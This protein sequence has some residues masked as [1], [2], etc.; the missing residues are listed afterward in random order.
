MKN[1]F[2]AHVSKRLVSQLEAPP[3]TARACT[4]CPALP[5]PLA[6]TLKL[7]S[8]SLPIVVPTLAT[9]VDVSIYGPKDIFKCDLLTDKGCFG[10]AMPQVD[11]ELDADGRAMV[12]THHVQTGKFLYKRKLS[13]MMHN[14]LVAANGRGRLI[15]ASV[16]SK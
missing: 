15:S 14:E 16:I 7:T 2:Q 9:V 11:Y 5:S 1:N 13:R 12:S 3:P 6:A 4:S 8:L 10:S